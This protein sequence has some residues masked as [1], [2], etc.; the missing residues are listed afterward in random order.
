MGLRSIP[1]G[2]TAP[3][4]FRAAA[5]CAGL[6][7]QAGLADLA[8]IYSE[9]PAAVAAVFT[10]N[11]VQAAPIQV[12]RE[13]L[14]AT[15]GT[16]QAVVVNAGN[17]NACTGEQGLA[18]ARATA[19]TVAAGLGLAPTAVLVASTGVIGVPLPLAKVKS[20][21]ADLLGEAPAGRPPALARS[22]E[23]DDQ[24]AR[25]M[26]TTDTFPKF[27]AVEFSL[28]GVTARLGGVAKG[29]GMIHPDLATMLAFLTTDA[30][31]PPGLLAQAFREEV[32]CSFNS[33]TVDGDTSTNDTALLLANG[34]A[35]NAPLQAGTAAY[36]TFRSALAEV[37]GFL[38]RE[39]A[40]DGE[41]ATKL[42]TIEVTGAAS[43]EEARAIGRTVGT[44]N[45]VKTA[46]FGGDVN[47]GRILAAAGR[48]PAA[49][50]PV[51][52][53]VYLA[54][55]LVARGGQACPFDE[56]TLAK[57]LEG[58]EIAIRLDLHQGTAAATVWSCDLSY[59]YVRI[60]GS[61]R[62]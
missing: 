50:D 11:R 2:I 30:V 58:K 33:I 14:A 45:L 60:N 27:K 62:T 51:R 16:A 4:G 13:H 49:V 23:I 34:Q 21:L 52:T 38:A 17:A 57:K 28:D 1:G 61:Y 42:L 41:G 19:A 5:G 31:I 47:W 59:D 32:D 46:M 39:I 25:A 40:R 18:D 12:C 48:A 54:G 8:V 55:T 24:V 44:S 10:R 56:A 3:L 37:L 20:G 9:V 15:G 53:D 36:D 43:T 7:R 22:P 26:M 29:S 6:K 35:G